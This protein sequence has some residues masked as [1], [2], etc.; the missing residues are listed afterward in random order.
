MRLDPAVISLPCH[1]LSSFCANISWIDQEKK[2][3]NYTPAD[4]RRRC[5]LSVCDDGV[6]PFIIIVVVLV[7]NVV[8]KNKNIKYKIYQTLVSDARDPTRLQ[9][10][11]P[12]PPCPALSICVSTSIMWVAAMLWLWLMKD[13]S[14]SEIM[15][16]CWTWS[17]SFFTSTPPVP[18]VPP[19][20]LH[21]V[22]NYGNTYHNK[23]EATNHGG[24]QIGEGIESRVCVS[25]IR[26]DFY[27]IFSLFEPLLGPLDVSSFFLFSGMLF[28]G[29]Y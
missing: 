25:N 18:P 8:E 23:G 21:I 24:E 13:S 12:S 5:A 27:F 22:K 20:A 11:P 26:Y 1:C 29:F 9:P 2:K 6:E 7:N 15:W 10:A 4:S 28:F 19:L 16:P 3:E 17:F 14:K